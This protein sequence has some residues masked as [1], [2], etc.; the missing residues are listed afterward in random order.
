MFVNRYI[1][2]DIKIS[3]G[4]RSVL[5]IGGVIS[6]G[7]VEPSLQL[8]K[9]WADFVMLEKARKNIRTFFSSKRDASYREKFSSR[10]FSEVN[11]ICYNLSTT[12]APYI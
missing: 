7:S 12:A 8:R 3:F 5:G 4:R 6:A 2:V 10:Y 9:P 1:I 11:Y